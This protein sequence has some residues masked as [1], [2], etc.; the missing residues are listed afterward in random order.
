MPQSLTVRRRGLFHQPEFEAT[1]YGGKNAEARSRGV[2]SDPAAGRAPP[3]RARPLVVERDVATA[4]GRRAPVAP[5]DYLAGLDR[6]PALPVDLERELVAAAQSGEARARARLVE[7]FTPLIASVARVYRDS[8]RIDRVELLQEGVIGLLR[9][10]ERYD[11]SRGTPFWAYAAWWVR[12]AMQ[13]LVAELT[14]PVVLSDR[15]LRRLSRIK[16]AHRRAMLDG[17]REPD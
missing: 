4:L 14:G 16:D 7:A 15:A 11:A 6:R 8:P 9:A 12:Q 5:A 1:P 2:L 10:L 17:G 13:Q 3:R